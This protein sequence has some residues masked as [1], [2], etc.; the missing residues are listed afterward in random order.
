MQQLTYRTMRFIPSLRVCCLL[1]WA[2]LIAA[3]VREA[4]SADIND[5]RSAFYRGDYD[6]CIE[7]TKAEVE[8]GIWND[9]WARQLIQC[10]LVTGQYT[11]AVQVYEQVA[12]RF[13]DSI[14]LRVLAAE[15]Y[16]FA[17][18][19]DRGSRLLSEV[20]EIVQAAPYRFS[21]R[22][23]M[24]AIGRYL[25]EMGEDARAV[26][27][28][29]Y[30]RSLKSDPKFVEAHVAIA[31]LALDKADYQEAVKSLERAAELR[32]DDP[33]LHYLMAVAW[34][35]SNSERATEALQVALKI[36]PLQVD[37]LLMQAENLIDAESYEDAEQ[38]L[39]TILEVNPKQALVWSQRAAIAHLRGDY[40]REGECR[41]EALS[42]WSMNPQV[43]YHI[44]KILS[45]HYRFAEGVKYQRRALHLDPSY[46]PAKFQLAQ[47]LLRS[48][49]DDEG[50]SLVDS[51]AAFD[52][53]NVVAFNLKTLQDRLAQF[54]T[55]EQDGFVVRMETREARIYGERVLELLS[56]AKQVLTAKYEHELSLP[57]TVEIFPEQSDFAIR[58]FGLPGGAGFLG[59]CFGS[60]ITANSPASQ[61]DTPSNW[62][63][64]LWHEFCHVVT[65]QKT[66][67]RMPRWLSEGISVYEELE[68]D[69]SWGQS[70]SP[71]YK[72]M[73]LGEDFVPL[74]ELSSAFLS[75]KSPVHLQFAYY[76]SSLA[77]RYLIETHGLPLLRKTLVDLGAGVP[78]TEAFASRYGDTQAL[79]EDF[80]AYVQRQTDSFLPDTDF[81]KEDLPRNADLQQWQE[82]L[83]EHPNNYFA[84]RMVTEQLLAR[85]DW[86]AACAA[87]QR[88]LKLFPEDSDAGGALD[89]LAIAARE[90]GDAELE[91]QTLERWVAMSADHLPPLLRLVALCRE[92]EQWQDVVK[93]ST[94]LLAVQPLLPTGHEA[95]AEA[96]RQ[97]NKPGLAIGA[98]HALQEMQPLDPSGLH[99]QLAEMMEQADLLPA[100]RREVLLAL[101]E[102][103]RFRAAQQLLKKIHGRL[104]PQ[105]SPSKFLELEVPEDGSPPR[106]KLRKLD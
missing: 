9:V 49:L 91:R 50:W 14:P 80:E 69:P 101:E 73:L 2:L 11:E 31:E 41:K 30:D 8:R 85:R 10:Y 55:L 98:L 96:A 48:G 47:D 42:T 79:D 78:L 29:F 84:Q 37:C 70:M 65:L 97:L 90:A 21:G 16:R 35:P 1:S 74:S 33:R 40:Q 95:L 44:G 82:W 53:Y 54:T 27:D 51:V 59:V 60:L 12:Q 13:S 92:A 83:K 18:Q 32:P 45:Q 62:E 5:A 26:L 81:D 75:P 93:H 6:G 64:V 61:R 87:A 28:A 25:L 86:T 36:N 4:Y 52:K 46:M 104:V 67:N 43:D 19:H 68:R 22:D 56:Q 103:P 102:T 72:Q 23:N 17:G 105:V 94:H 39:A 89:L 15:A 24:L 7:M 71:L 38:I 77:V 76:E 20:P 88:L 58:T 34:A 57:V 66:N 3:D 100:A 99:F 63:S 106:P